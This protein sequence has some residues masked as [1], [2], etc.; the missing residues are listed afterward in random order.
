MVK[1]ICKK[2]GELTKA[3]KEFLTQDVNA[4]SVCISLPKHAYTCNL[5]CPTCIGD[6]HVHVLMLLCSVVL[7]VYHVSEHS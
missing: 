3:K 6:V 4:G 7:S 1:W 2:E 5:V